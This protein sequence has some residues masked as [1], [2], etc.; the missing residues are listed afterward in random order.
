MSAENREL[1]LRHHDEI[2]SKGN[3]QAV[4]EIY[5]TGFVGH[6]P[7]ALD[8]VGTAGVKLVA[9]S[10]REAFPDFREVVEDIVADGDKVVTRFT[11][12]GTHLGT[13]R[14]LAPTGKAFR[15]AE[16]GIFRLSNGRIAE[17]WGM[18]DRLGMFQQLGIVPGAWP[19]ME[20]LY[21]IAMDATVHDVGLTPSGRRRIVQVTGGTFEGPRLRGRVLPGGGDWLI[22]RPDGSRRLDVRITL[23]THDGD[24][25]Y[26]TYGGVFCGPP[27]VMERLT[28]GEVVEKSEYYFRT[29]PLFET[30]SEKYDWLNRVLA[31]GVGWRQPARVGYSVY[32][33]T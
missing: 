4:D 23:E 33:I 5:A 31:V 8:W 32:A 7:G 3:L 19:P 25:I 24:L 12:S 11:A 10:V 2:W 1:V 21:E 17:K 27:L 30:A 18:A 20:L 22:E 26:A 6:H 15:M 13:F 29:A 28:R 16:M 9:R 14:G